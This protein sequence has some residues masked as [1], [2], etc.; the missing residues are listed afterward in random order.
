VDR[1]GIATRSTWIRQ[2]KEKIKMSNTKSAPTTA[3]TENGQVKSSRFNLDVM[4]KA[5]QEYTASG[6]FQGKKELIEIPVECPP[7]NDDF[8]RVRDGDDYWVEC[9][10]VDFAPENGRK[11][12]YFIAPELTD[13][14]PPEIQNVVK[15]SRLYVTMSRRGRVTAIW[16]IKIYDDGPGLLSSRTALECAEQAKRLWVRIGWQNRI[17]YVPFVAQDDFGEPEWTAHSF[18]ELLDIAFKD[19]YIDTLEHPVIRDLM[20]RADR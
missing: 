12:T 14:L 17:G 4:R 16:R 10:T 15:W 11:E 8:I 13:S 9:M 18:T 3:G 5:A 1:V 20:G 7:P 2:L 19:T 6:G